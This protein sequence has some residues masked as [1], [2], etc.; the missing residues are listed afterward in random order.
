MHSTKT[1][2]GAFG[3]SMGVGAQKDLGGTKLLPEK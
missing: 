2:K 3:S 1:V